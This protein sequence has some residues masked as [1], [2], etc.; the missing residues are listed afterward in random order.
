VGEANARVLRGV[1]TDT[2]TTLVKNAVM[3]LARVVALGAGAVL[4]VRNGSTHSARS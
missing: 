1:A 4:V 3:G 2:R